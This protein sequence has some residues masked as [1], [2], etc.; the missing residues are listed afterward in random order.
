MMN[1][2]PL[3]LEIERI[4]F[5]IIRNN[6]KTLVFVATDS[7]EGVT[8]LTIAIAQRALLAGQSTLVVD[9]NLYHPC[10]ES[11]GMSISVNENRLFPSPELVGISGENVVF[12]GIIA[13]SKRETLM[14][15]R[16]P[17]VLESY[18]VEWSKEYDLILFDTSPISRLNA[19]NIPPERVAAAVD[20]TIL[21]VMAGHTTEAMVSE[22]IKKLDSSGAHLLGCIIN[23]KNNPSLKVEILREIECLKKR[24][25]KLAAKLKKFIIE[26]HLLSLE[27]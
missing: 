22:S 2:P 20:G 21:V 14:E 6:Y 10:L 26:S 19:N 9:L 11:Q 15:L 18:I 1:I 27:I 4:Y 24:F 3:N 23:D 25:P 16:R 17:S 12:T 13:P 7:G 8:S 5:Q